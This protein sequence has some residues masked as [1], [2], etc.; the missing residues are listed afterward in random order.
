[1]ITI[2]LKYYFIKSHLSSR[3]QLTLITCHNNRGIWSRSRKKGQHKI[4]AKSVWEACTLSRRPAPQHVWG[5]YAAL[6]T[7]YSGNTCR[8][9]TFC[10]DK[11]PNGKMPSRYFKVR[12]WSFK[13]RFHTFVGC[14]LR[15]SANRIPRNSGE[16]PFYHINKRWRHNSSPFLCFFLCYGSNRFL[17]PKDHSF[18]FIYF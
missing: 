13:N 4:G 10:S 15:I 9:R 6:E 17:W 3:I 14:D 8:S 2:T 18:Q 1:M 12:V 5:F 7:N 16:T 11:S